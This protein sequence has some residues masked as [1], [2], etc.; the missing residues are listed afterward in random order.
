MDN[1][2][3]SLV[4]AAIAE[5][6][7]PA[8]ATSDERRVLM[9]GAVIA[10]N[11]PDIDLAY[12]WITPAPLGY[13]L[14]HRGYTHT[15]AGLLALSVALPLVMRLW[16]AVRGLGSRGRGWLW[17]LVA[18]N[19]LGHVALDGLNWYGVHPFYPF[20]ARWYLRRRRLRV[21]TGRLAGAWGRRG[22]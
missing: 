22:V 18:V 16:P 13:L 9:A 20:N 15:V 6:A 21:R 1:I 11:L 5:L 3:H 19:L 12:T 8:S 7:L 17:G 14:H 2:T 10:A 4:G